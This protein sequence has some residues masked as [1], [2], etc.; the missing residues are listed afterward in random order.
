MKKRTIIKIFSLILALVMLLP[1]L[2]IFAEETT[3]TPAGTTSPEE[4]GTTDPA[5]TGTTAPDGETTTAPEGS[6]T[7]G[8]STGTDSELPKYDEGFESIP[9]TF[10][11]DDNLHYLAYKNTTTYSLVRSEKAMILVKAKLLEIQETLMKLT[12]E[13]PDIVL[14]LTPELQEEYGS[15]MGAYFPLVEDASRLTKN[16]IVIGQYDWD[17]KKDLIGRSDISKMA[18]ELITSASDFFIHVTENGDVWVIGGANTTTVVAFDFMVERILKIDREQRYIAIEKG[19]TYVYHH[20]ERDNVPFVINNK[21]ENAFEFTLQAYSMEKDVFCRLTYTGSNGWRIQ[22]K[23]VY[24]EDYNNLGAAQ[25]LATTI[26]EDSDYKGEKLTYTENG[27]QLTITAPDG[28]YAVVDTTNGVTAFYTKSG[29]LAQKFLGATHTVYHGTHT[30]TARFEI[31][32]TDVMYGAGGQFKE[33]NLNGQL[34]TLYTNDIADNTSSVYTAIP[35]IINTKGSAVFMNRNEYMTIDI[36]KTVA[37]EMTFTVTNGS[38]DCYVFTTESVADAIT[39]Y[40]KISGFAE[41][42]ADWSYGML[43]CRYNKEFTNVDGVYEM[44]AKMEKYGLAW[45]GVILEGWDPYDTDKHSDLKEL[46]DYLHA[47]GKKVIVY[48]RAGNL[49]APHNYSNY[50][51][52]Y[53]AYGGKTPSTRVPSNVKGEYLDDKDSA[54]INGSTPYYYIDVSNPDA[55]KWFFNEYWTMLL[56]DIG[57]DGAKIDLGGLIVDTVGTLNFYNANLATAGAHHWYASSFNALLWEAISSKPDSGI[58]YINCAG[59]GAQRAPYMW[60]GDQT[61]VKNRLQRQLTYVLTAG[62]S[63]IPFVSYDIGT[64]SYKDNEMMDIEDDAEFFLRAVQMTAFMPSMQTSGTVRRP[65]D[66]AEYVDAKGK[67]SMAYVTQLYKLYTK[68]HESLIPYLEECSKEATETGMPVVRQLVL[69]YANDANVYKMKDQYML[70]D[71]FLVAPEVELKEKRD[72]YLPEGKWLDLNSGKEITVSAG[73]T[74]IEDYK[75]SM[76]QV[77][78]FYNMNTTSEVAADVLTSVR[79]AMDAINNVEIP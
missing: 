29:K 28:S 30:V 18:K 70:G 16:E 36:G 1:I 11:F 54:T 3:G 20:E 74:T 78:V 47:L 68:L 33:L 39:E 38:L 31:A 71:A 59:I 48:V 35:L 50:L 25:L 26:G 52:T 19:L 32:K 58:C 24:S 4:S 55:V 44:V 27:N 64:S 56:N 15:R 79:A 53:L 2:P 7:P 72:I 22:D 65:Y 61:R 21:G 67:N 45:N 46:C 40:S 77:A 12:A 13:D 69:N 49:P 9:D 63:G 73:G 37:T 51:V 8:G 60:A 41:M 62:L 34:L 75:V 14:G 6:E 57:V 23:Q 5:D 17:T 66:F 76:G 10:E 43:V 42:P